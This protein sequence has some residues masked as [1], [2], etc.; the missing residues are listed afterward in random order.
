MCKSKYIINEEYRD[1]VDKLFGNNEI[2][3]AFGID[4]R[5]C[6]DKDKIKY[7]KFM[8]IFCKE[9]KKINYKSQKISVV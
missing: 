9:Y 8:S 3:K 2:D 6:N 7:I 1:V 5:L 4:S